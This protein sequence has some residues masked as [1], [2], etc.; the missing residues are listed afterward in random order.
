[1]R[2][3]WLATG[4]ALIAAQGRASAAPAA[5]DYAADAKALDAIIA[6]NYAYLDRFGDTVPSSAKLDAERDAVAD[7]DSLLHYAEDK[8]AALAD[9]H[10]ITGSS[11]KTSWGL[12]PSY[13]DLWIVADA[14]GYRIDA[15][16]DGSPAQ[17]AQIAIGY[18][19][20]AVDGVPIDAAIAAYWH[21]LGLE[22]VTDSERRAFAARVLAAGRRDRARHLVVDADDAD[23]PLTLPNLYQSRPGDRPPVTLTVQTRRATIRFNDSLGNSD[24]IAAFDAAMATVPQGAHLVIDLTDT[25]SGGD[26]LIARAVMSW[27][28]DRPRFYQKHRLVAEERSSGIVREWVEEVYPRAGKH[29]AGPVS[30]RVGRW[31]GS[32]GEGMAIGFMSIGVPVC[33]GAMA[34]LRGAVYDFTLPAT[35]MVVKLPAERVYTPGGKPREDVVPPPCR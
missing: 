22:A 14:D 15:V 24:T 35:G 27:F 3:V 32:M 5:T 1:M 10:A 4:L 18:H 25:G 26:S 30:V 20:K 31:T 9:H 2:T 12:V 21:D 11:F 7:H 17:G 34:G 33:G 23:M 6:E 28:V 19:L 29:F 13:A 16:K 8:I